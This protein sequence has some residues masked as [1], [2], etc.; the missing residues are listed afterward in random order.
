MFIDSSDRPREAGGPP[1]H[2]GQVIQQLPRAQTDLVGQ[3]GL[4]TP[5]IRQ[6][7]RGS[8]L[9][10]THSR[11][12]SRVSQNKRFCFFMDVL[13]LFLSVLSR[14]VIQLYDHGV[15]FLLIL[16]Y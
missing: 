5:P 15:D 8:S 12:H 6:L 10:Y 3:H 2:S 13:R 11:T 16:T 1:L 9:L 4:S 7:L 14:D